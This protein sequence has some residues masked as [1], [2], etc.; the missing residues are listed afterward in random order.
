MIDIIASHLYYFDNNQQR[1]LLKSHLFLLYNSFSTQLYIV[2]HNERFV[3]PLF[4][5]IIAES[6]IS[7]INAST[8][9]NFTFKS[10][11][12]L[13]QLENINVIV[14]QTNI[15]MYRTILIF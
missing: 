12:T 3:T 14:I 5:I 6:G 10:E 4:N 1:Y 15:F 7:S 2:T 11:S 9:S 8:L 13:S